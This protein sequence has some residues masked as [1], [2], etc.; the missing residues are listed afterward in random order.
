[1]AFGGSL[2]MS[3]TVLNTK[4]VVSLV[5]HQQP[6]EASTRVFIL[7]IDRSSKSQESITKTRYIN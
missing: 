3:G 6:N 5:N 1:M 4:H 7:L 2:Y